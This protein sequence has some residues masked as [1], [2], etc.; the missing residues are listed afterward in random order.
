[1]AWRSV[2]AV[3]TPEA[4]SDGGQ[5]LQDLAWHS[6]R[7][8]PSG[9]SQTANPDSRASAASSNRSASSVQPAGARTTRRAVQGLHRQLVRGSP[10]QCRRQGVR[11]VDDHRVVLADD[12]LLHGIDWASRVWLVMTMSAAR[13]WAMAFSAQHCSTNAHPIPVRT[14]ET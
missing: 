9:A 2:A 3:A 7:R 14:P 8:R 13:A 6:A 5:R 1:M 10:L 12:R 11:L 4:L